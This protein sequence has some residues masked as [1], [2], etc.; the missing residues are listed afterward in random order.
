MEEKRQQ[1]FPV[2]VNMSLLKDNDDNISGAVGTVRDITDRQKIE[3][4]ILRLE[5][6]KRLANLQ[7][8]LPMILIMFWRLFL[9]GPSS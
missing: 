7:A 4:Q 5:K 9:A 1:Y 6:L 8:V 3:S 2:E